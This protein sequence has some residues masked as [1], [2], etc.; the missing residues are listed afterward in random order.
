MT[1]ILLIVALWLAVNVAVVAWRLIVSRRPAIDEPDYAAPDPYIVSLLER[2]QTA[3]A[4]GKGEP[5]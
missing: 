2:R 3:G 4:R 5:S 1:T